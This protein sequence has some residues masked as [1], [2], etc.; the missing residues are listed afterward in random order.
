MTL[1]LA[2]STTSPFAL[3]EM[4]EHTHAHTIKWD[5]SQLSTNRFV[6]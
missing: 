4:P 3:D 1:I 5:F 6:M 2:L